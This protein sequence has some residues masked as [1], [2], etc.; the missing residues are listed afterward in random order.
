MNHFVEGAAPGFAGGEGEFFGFEGVAEGEGD[1]EV[2]VGGEAEEGASLIVLVDGG[3]AGA[4]AE[5]PGGELHVGGGLSG[6]EHDVEAN[7]RVGGDDGEAEGGSGEVS[8]K[9]AAFGE[10]FESGSVA[11]GDE[12]PGLHV[13]GGLGAASRVK[14]GVEGVIGEGVGGEFADGAFGADGGLDRERA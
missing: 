7:F 10:G 4:D 12:V 1:A 9:V 6:V 8:G 3:E 14:D 11:D 5:F 13:F 2:H